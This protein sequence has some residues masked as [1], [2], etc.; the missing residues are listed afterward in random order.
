M[1]RP[2]N[3]QFYAYSGRALHKLLGP[4]YFPWHLQNLAVA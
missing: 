3:F 1:V 2:I 4:L